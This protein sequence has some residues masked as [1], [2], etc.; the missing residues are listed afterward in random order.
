MSYYSFLL[1]L[2]QLDRITKIRE[3]TLTKDDDNE[4]CMEASFTVSIFFRH[5][6]S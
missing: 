3:L 6:R 2:E 5:G 1:E 4:G